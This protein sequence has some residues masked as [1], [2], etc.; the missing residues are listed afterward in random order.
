MN[1][2]Q[3]WIDNV[4]IPNHKNKL[5]GLS[6]RNRGDGFQAIFENIKLSDGLVIIETGTMRPGFTEEGD[7]QSTQLFDSFAKYLNGRVYSVDIDPKTKE[8]AET[9][10]DTSVTKLF[11]MD[12]IKFLWNFE[13]E[14]PCL[15]Y[16]DS[17]DV[18]FSNPV[19]SNLHHMKEVAAISRYLTKG[20]LVAVDDCRFADN[21]FRVP[22]G[23]R[24][25][26][27]GKGNYVSSFMKDINAE[28]IFDGYQKVW[29]I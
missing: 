16:L 22:Y 21:D 2:R 3:E 9:K 15:F 20:V 11:T 8:F 13:V 23:V 24:A 18:D 4:F 28:L 17:Y 12:S 7:G 29:R 1:K 10:V 25:A 14:S 6:E 19:L 26:D 5:N 27:V